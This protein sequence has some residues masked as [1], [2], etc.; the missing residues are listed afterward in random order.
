MGNK[1]TVFGTLHGGRTFLVVDMEVPEGPRLFDRDCAMVTV[2]IGT[3]PDG[4]LRTTRLAGREFYSFQ[5]ANDGAP[6][7]DISSEPTQSF[8]DYRD[9]NGAYATMAA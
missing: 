1:A 9:E 2:A 7:V 8:A 5:F 3:N 6:P 4:S